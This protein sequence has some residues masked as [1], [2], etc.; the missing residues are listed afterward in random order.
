[1][2]VTF[3]EYKTWCLAIIKEQ[4]WCLRTKL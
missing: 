1:L 4:G 3:Y 2:T